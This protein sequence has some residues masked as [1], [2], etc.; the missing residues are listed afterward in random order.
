[1]AS[2]LS[3]EVNEYTL[4]IKEL[5]QE[6]KR[7]LSSMYRKSKDAHKISAD[8]QTEKVG[9]SYIILTMILYSYVYIF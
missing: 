1:M 8:Y 6:N 2:K 5:E 4:K 3:E 7:L 9:I